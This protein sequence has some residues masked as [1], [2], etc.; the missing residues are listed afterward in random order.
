MAIY[1]LEHSYLNWRA[2]PCGR[3]WFVFM[4]FFILFSTFFFCFLDS[5][6]GLIEFYQVHDMTINF[7]IFFM[8]MIC[9]LRATMHILDG[10]PAWSISSHMRTRFERVSLWFEV[11]H[12][13]PK[14]GLWL[15][16]VFEKWVILV[17]MPQDINRRWFQSITILGLAFLVIDGFW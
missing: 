5:C 16:S 9:L 3:K 1:H 17:N 15:K 8:L 7:F 2:I 14:R 4:Q 11:Y 12:F 10:L 6:L 13:C